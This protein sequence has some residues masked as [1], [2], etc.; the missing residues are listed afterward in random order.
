M[1]LMKHY[2]SIFTETQ[3]KGFITQNASNQNMTDWK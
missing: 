3:L 1:K 2:I